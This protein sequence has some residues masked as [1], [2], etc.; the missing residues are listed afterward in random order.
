M[1]K[2]EELMQRNEQIIGMSI[3]LICNRLNAKKFAYY[4]YEV[5]WSKKKTINEWYAQ[6]M[7]VQNS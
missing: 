4:M 3:W 5:E 6:V 1:N 2:N 7:N